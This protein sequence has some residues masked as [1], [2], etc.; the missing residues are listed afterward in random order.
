M[1]QFGFSFCFSCE[2]FCSVYYCGT[3]FQL[4][5]IC[6]GAFYIDVVVVFSIFDLCN[7]FM[8]KNYVLLIEQAGL[9]VILPVTL[10]QE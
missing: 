5:K 4:R 10:L 3:Q 9:G 2:S 6:H 8:E 7:K 1:L